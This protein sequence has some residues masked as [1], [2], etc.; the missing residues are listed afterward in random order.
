[1][2]GNI[3]ND[4]PPIFTEYNDQISFVREVLQRKRENRYMPYDIQQKDMEMIEEY[5]R[6][7]TY[8]YLNGNET[9]TILGCTNLFRDLVSIFD[10]K[11]RLHSQGNSS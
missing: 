4:L 2:D 6:N 11:T 7:Y 8:Y 3:I 1:M 9:T 5:A 10:H